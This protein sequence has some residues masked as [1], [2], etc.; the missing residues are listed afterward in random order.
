MKKFLLKFIL[1]FSRII[2]LVFFLSVPFSILVPEIDL[3][4]KDRGP[5]MYLTCRA[6][7]FIFSY[8]S[9]CLVEHKMRALAYFGIA[10]FTVVIWLPPISFVIEP[11]ITEFI[12]KIITLII[13]VIFTFILFISI[14][15]IK[16]T[17]PVT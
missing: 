10:I 13:S 17:T 16:E 4:F 6:L 7:V 8:L 5:G 9:L 14:K 11:R 1:V 12:L 2:F 3:W 15:D